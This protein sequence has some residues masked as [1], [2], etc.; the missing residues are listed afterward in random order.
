MK[1]ARVLQVFSKGDQVFGITNP[2]FCGAQAEFTVAI[3]GRIAQK[4]Q[5]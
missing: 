5:A 2:G 3:A 1:L 4:P